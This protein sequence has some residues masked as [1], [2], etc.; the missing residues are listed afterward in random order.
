M[1][2]AI[3]GWRVGELF[4]RKLKNVFVLSRPTLA[5]ISPARPESATTDSSP[6]DAPWPMQCR[7]ELSLFKGL[8][9]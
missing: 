8:P 5:V 3:C 9:E 4:L 7:R 1:I 2:G 6:L